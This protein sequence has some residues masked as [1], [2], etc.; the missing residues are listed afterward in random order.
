MIPKHNH[1]RCKAI[2]DA[3]RDEDCTICGINDSTTVFAHLD[4]S[5]AGKGMKIKADDIAGMF[6]C[7]N[8]HVDYGNG[9]YA[10]YGNDMHAD[11]IGYNW[12]IT[13]AMYRTWRRLWDRGIIGEI[14]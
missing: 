7:V 8:C 6:L 11:K 5:W 14:K 3:A 1:I 13:R 12:Q 9:M 4:E 10:D 2:R